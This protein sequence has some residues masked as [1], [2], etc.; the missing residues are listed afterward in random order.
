MCDEIK[1]SRNFLYGK[2]I[3]FR[4][5]VDDIR[6]KSKNQDVIIRNIVFKVI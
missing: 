2:I 1:Q 4:K 6:K 3:V 5:K